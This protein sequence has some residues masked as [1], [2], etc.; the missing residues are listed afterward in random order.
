M[1]KSEFIKTNIKPVFLFAFAVVF[2]TACGSKEEKKIKQ[3]AVKVTVQQIEKK[4]RQEELSFSGTIEADNAVSVGFSVP[5]TV[6]SVSV[7][8]GQ[9]VHAGQLLATIDATEYNNALLIAD[10]GLEQAEDMFTRLNGLYQKGSLPAKDFIEIKTKVAQARANKNLSVKRVNDTKLYAPMPGIITAKSVEK[11]ATAAPGVPA[12]TII[13]TD[14]VYATIS[15]PESEIG[16]LSRGQQAEIFIATLGQSFSGK[17]TII[18]PQADQ[19][20]KTYAVKVQLKNPGGKLLPG[21]IAQTKIATGSS[22]SQITIPAMAVVRD[23]DDITYVFVTDEHQKVVRKR[24]TASGV[25]GDD[26]I[27]SDGLNQGDKVV[28]SGQTRL[29]DGVTVAL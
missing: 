18:N 24:V 17:I 3:S 15:V 22:V 28:V 21:M 27:I 26:V 11:G 7:Q 4:G 2:V 1:K 10:A 19:V 6:S 5:G 29:K 16:K 14:L 9:F 20:T 25:Q 12:F 23:A 13:K 8:E